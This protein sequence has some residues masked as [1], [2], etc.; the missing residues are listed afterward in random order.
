MLRT[1]TARPARRAGLRRALGRRW[2]LGLHR[3]REDLEAA[4]A[5][6][7]A[8]DSRWEMALAS[9]GL[10]AVWTHRVAHAM[11][12]RGGPVRLPARLLSQAS[13]T[14]TG[15]EIHPGARIGRRVFID[16]GMGVVIGETAEVGDDV[17]MYHGVTLGGRSLNP[18]KRHPTVG[19]GVTLGA[20]ARL[21]GPVVVGNGASVGAN[22]VVVRDVPAGAV[23][24]GV[25][26][27][28]KAA[29][30]RDSVEDDPA[31]WI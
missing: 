17:L 9:P 30:A 21:I 16:H 14:L 20:G 6:D 28:I 11:W 4:V 12:N 22:A 10:H 1:Q 24:V 2:G 7:P 27:T 19:S 15:V 18:V 25:P 3:L 8:T 23:A 31:L 26:A 5:R 13:R 29:A